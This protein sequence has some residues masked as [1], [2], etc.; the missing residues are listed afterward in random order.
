MKSPIP[1]EM[2]GRTISNI[3]V[4][5]VGIVV[6]AAVMHIGQVWG[7]VRRVLH[8][9]MPLVIGFAIAFILL[10]TVRRLERLFAKL[11]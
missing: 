6:Y 10:P 11:F 5:C 2:R 1:H 4:V 8:T 7:V 3:I 9:A